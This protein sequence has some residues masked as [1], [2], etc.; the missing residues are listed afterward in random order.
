MKTEL[1]YGNKLISKEQMKLEIFEYIEIC[2]NRKRRNSALNYLNIEEFNNQIN[3]KNVALIDVQFLF[4]YPAR[5]ARKKK[6]RDMMSTT[7]ILHLRW[8]QMRV[9]R[10]FL[11]STAHYILH[12]FH[13]AINLKDRK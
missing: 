1:I 12:T 6:E 3:Y 7:N 9:L 13:L 4:A 2:Y 8:V 5:Y 11:S 10:Y